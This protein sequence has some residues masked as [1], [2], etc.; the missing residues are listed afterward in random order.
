MQFNFKVSLTYCFQGIFS[1]CLAPHPINSSPVLICRTPAFFPLL[2]YESYVPIPIS[3]KHSLILIL[4]IFSKTTGKLLGSSHSLSA[5]WDVIYLS[6]ENL[7]LLGVKCILSPVHSLPT[8]IPFHQCLVHSFC[9]VRVGKLSFL[10]SVP[11]QGKMVG[12]ALL[13]L[14]DG[15]KHNCRHLYLNP[16]LSG[17]KIHLLPQH[18]LKFY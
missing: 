15:P 18:L 4:H 1:Y 10:S 14:I 6:Q 3:Q 7:I 11:H 5:L 8:S 2:G 17:L 13:C 12:S 16:L 9:K